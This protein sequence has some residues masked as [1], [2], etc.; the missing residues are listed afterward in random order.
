MCLEQS[1]NSYAFS[2]G[3]VDRI[4]EEYKAKEDASREQTASLFKHLLVFFN[5]GDRSWAI[6]QNLL[7]G[8]KDV[9]GKDMTSLMTYAVLDAYKETNYP[10]PIL[11]VKL[12][13]ETP[14]KLYEELGEFFFSPGKLTPSFF[15]DES[16]FPI[17]KHAGV[18]EEDLENYAVAGCQE[19]LIMGKDNGNT[20]NSWLN[21]GKD[22]ELT[23]NDG[24]S[25][26]S[27]QKIGLGY[28]ELGLDDS[29]PETVLENLRSAFYK[30]LTHFIDRMVLAA[31]G[32]SCALANLR[33][34]FLSASMGG[35][36]TGVDIRDKYKQGSRYN[37]SGCL[38]HGLSVVADSFIAVDDLLDKRPKD[39]GLLFA[40]LKDNFKGYEDL[41]QFLLS[42]VK[43]GNNVTRVDKEASVIANKVSDMV[44]GKK[45]Y[46]GNPFRPDWST[47][48]THLLYGY[49]V[50]ATPDGRLAREM[51]NYG[52]DPLYGEAN[53]G[54][55]FRILS[56]QKLPFEKMTGGYASHFGINPNYFPEKTMEEKGYAFYRKIIAPLFFAESGKVNPFYLYVNVTTPDILR[57]VKEDPKKIC[58]EWSLYYAYSWYFC[59]F[60]GFVTSYS[61]RY[62]FEIGS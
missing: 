27:G 35:I 53:S 7:V 17:L 9:N 42:A 26:I 46:L 28:T 25:L 29:K 57:K 34:P 48:S 37:G 49:W 23:S 30:Q 39:A 5:V 2:V 60:P 54:L 8:G 16:I 62:H 4:F 50:G 61:E 6:S 36:E 56:T 19:P 10:Q 20:T 3:N 11:S 32:C 52:V 31:N 24:Y 14:Q 38:I 44:S 45:N 58:S 12:H 43:F 59:E 41:R 55:G 22:L 21:L 33:V 13:K 18:A 51:L 15:N 40:A 47:P 1:P